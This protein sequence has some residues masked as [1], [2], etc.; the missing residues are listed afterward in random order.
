M[1]GGGCWKGREEEEWVGVEKEV[2]EGWAAS[3]DG[4]ISIFL[5]L[6]SDSQLE[7]LLRKNLK[8]WVRRGWKGEG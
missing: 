6:P 5:S 1:L 8:I 2:L 7:V 4:I 3:R